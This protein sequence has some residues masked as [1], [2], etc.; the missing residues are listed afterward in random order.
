M[1]SDFPTVQ[2]VSIC[3]AAARV[4]ALINPSAFLSSDCDLHFAS[5]PLFCFLGISP[6]ASYCT[7]VPCVYLT[8]G[9][10]SCRPYLQRVNHGCPIHN[11]MLYCPMDLTIRA[12]RQPVTGAAIN[13]PPLLTPLMPP[14]SLPCSFILK[15]FTSEPSGGP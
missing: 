11:Y 1:I 14:A 13:A 12:L 15:S 9:G 6:L 2:Q 10:V 8:H 5:P 3:R 4:L 7:A